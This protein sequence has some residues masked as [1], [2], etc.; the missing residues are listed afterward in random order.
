EVFAELQRRHLVQDELP[1]RYNEVKYLDTV[2]WI[3]GKLQ[4]AA[5]LR[6]HR[7]PP[8]DIL[9]L[10]SGPGHFQLVAQFMG[11][12]S[13]GLDVPLGPRLA[14]TNRHL[15][16]DLCAFFAVEKTSFAI[17]ALK[18]LPDFGRRFDLVTSFMTWFNSHRDN[19]PWSPEE[20]SFFLCDVR[21]R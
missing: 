4:H 1:R 18:P 13:F 11:H 6:L 5:E 12:R 7:S 14:S 8:L 16:D 20:W 15:Y 19:T 2:R 21:D 17:E 3:E 10:G 9:D